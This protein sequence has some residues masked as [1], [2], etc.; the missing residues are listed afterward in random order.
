MPRG[1]VS[2]AVKSG[3]LVSVDEHPDLSSLVR[4]HPAAV[5][6]AIDIP[7]S[8]PAAGEPRA[9]DIA[10]RKI[11]GRRASSLFLVPPREIL[12]AADYPEANFLAKKLTGRGLSRQSYALRTKILEAADL[13]ESTRDPR[14]WEVHP[15]LSFHFLARSFG[16]SISSPKKTWNGALERWKLLE[17]AGFAPPLE[18]VSTLSRAGFD[19]VLDAVAAA[20]TANR[21]A[22]GNAA[23]VPE[24][25]D[26]VLEKAP[27]G[28]PGVIRA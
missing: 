21:I 8:F 4:A 9:T 27:N 12:E 6:I 19:D 10:A 13:L 24:A 28:N 18:P 16:E 25:S 5:V 22:E 14:L 1:W 15:E 2:A 3:R 11:L 17:R 7:L 20:W 23:F 26:D